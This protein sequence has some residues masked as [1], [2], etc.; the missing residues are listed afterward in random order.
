MLLQIVQRNSAVLDLPSE[1]QVFVEAT[2]SGICKFSNPNAEIYRRIE[3]HIIGLLNKAVQ[4]TS[5]PTSTSSIIYD[6]E[7]FPQETPP[8]YQTPLESLYELKP[9]LEIKEGLTSE[10]YNVDDDRITTE[11]NQDPS[12]LRLFRGFSSLLPL[13]TTSS[14]KLV[15]DEK[16]IQWPLSESHPCFVVKKSLIAP[17]RRPSLWTNMAFL[18]LRLCRD[19][20]C[21]TV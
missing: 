14:T 6:T 9:T 10:N 7:D 8:P 15:V 13:H 16:S 11:H 3:D 4:A 2:H 5:V 21:L 12:V 19:I 1:D 18:P 20:D 17:Q